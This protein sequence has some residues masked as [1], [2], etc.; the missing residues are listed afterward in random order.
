MSSSVLGKNV[1]RTGACTQR[2]IAPRALG[3]GLGLAHCLRAGAILAR[4]CKADATTN[5]GVGRGSSQD[6][7]DYH[8]TKLGPNVIA[9]VKD[10]RAGGVKWGTATVVRNDS[11]SL[12]N[13]IRVLHLAVADHVDMLYGRRV[14]GVPDATRWIESYTLPGQLYPIASSPYASR[15]D[16]AYVDASLIEVVVERSWGSEEVALADLGPGAQVEVTQVIG[17]GFSPLLDSYN[18]LTH[19]LEEGRNLVLIAMG[20]RGMAAIRSA[21]NWQPVLAHAS[22]HSLTALYLAHSPGRAAFVPEW[23][24]WREAGMRL[25]PLYTHPAADVDD[26]AIVNGGGGGGAGGN[27]APGGQGGD[28]SSSGSS[29]GGVTVYGTSGDLDHGRCMDLLQL[30]LFAQ[31]GGFEGKYGCVCGGS[32]SRCSFLLAGLPGDMASTLAKQLSAKGV[33]YEHILFAQSDFF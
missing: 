32:S 19:A 9:S 24:S 17:R 6:D 5:R 28:V 4:P 26:D 31:E 21:L 3:T 27:G 20:T 8:E 30:A 23:D 7:M 25:R 10:L 16:S 2:R 12:D 14:K 1:Q 15:R 13:S 11:Q 18:G 33:A 22:S 29:S